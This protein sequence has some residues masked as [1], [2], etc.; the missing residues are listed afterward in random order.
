MDYV[1]FCR[2]PIEESGAEAEFVFANDPR[3]ILR[4]TK[5]VLN[6]HIHTRERTKRQAQKRCSVWTGL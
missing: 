1:S 4:Y 6:C 3:I 5:N 2:E